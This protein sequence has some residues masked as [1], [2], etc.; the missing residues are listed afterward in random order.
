MRKIETISLHCSDTNNPNH[1]N[2]LTIKKWH[3]SQPPLGRGWNDVGYHFF[4][5]NDGTIEIGRPIDS[6]PAAVEGHNQGMIAICLHGKE[7][8][9][10]NLKQFDQLEKLV[11]FLMIVFQIK[12]ENI[13]GH[14]FWNKGKLCPVF[15]VEIFKKRI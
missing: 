3:T 4:I 8:N 9:D 11:K 14:N 15:N 5:R 6:L 13:Q 1:D 7:I 10:F 12:K 2:I